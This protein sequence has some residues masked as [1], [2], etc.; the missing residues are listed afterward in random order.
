MPAGYR[1][2]AEGAD[3]QGYMNN[4]AEWVMPKSEWNLWAAHAVEEAYLV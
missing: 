1:G 3:E 4:H 2:V